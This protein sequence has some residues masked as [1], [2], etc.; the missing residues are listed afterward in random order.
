M[1]LYGVGFGPTT[2]NIVAGQIVSQSNTLSNAL[3]I[4]IGGTVAT[5]TYSGLSPNFVGLYQF[6]V[7]I[8]AIASNDATTFTATL[9]GI[10]VGQTLYIAVGK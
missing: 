1:I 9:G 5:T 8:P 6:N 7:V 4:K 3:Q 2:P 10:A